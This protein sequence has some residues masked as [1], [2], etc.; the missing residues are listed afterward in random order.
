TSS[1]KA[2]RVSSSME[3]RLSSQISTR[4]PSSWTPARALASWLTPSW[5]S[6]SEQIAWTWWS[7]GLSPGA[8]YGSNRPRSRRARSEEHTSELQS[9]E[10]LV[11]R[12]LL[13]NE[14]SQ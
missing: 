13:I 9:R 7:K 4:L 11:C 14:E 12:L 3:I 2:I 1:E 6:P 8:A 5:T 10:N